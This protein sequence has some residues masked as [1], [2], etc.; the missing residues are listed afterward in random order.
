MISKITSAQ[1]T[2]DKDEITVTGPMTFGPAEAGTDVLAIHFVLVRGEDFAHGHT[3]TNGGGANWSKTV[4]VIGAFEDGDVVQ[5]Y[6]VA[7]LLA[8]LGGPPM[9]TR[10]V[11]TL[12]WTEPVKI[13]D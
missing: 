10:A 2:P 7:V 5:A 3:Q 6:G 12:S 4:G 8:P 11:Q 9:H 1:L 13:T